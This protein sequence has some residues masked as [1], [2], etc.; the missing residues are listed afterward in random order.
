[1]E[2]EL[3]DGTVLEF[4]DGTDPAVIQATVKKMIAGNAPAAPAPQPAQPSQQTLPESGASK[5][6]S[7]VVGGPVEA[8][9][10]MATGMGASAVGGLAGLLGGGTTDERTQRIQDVSQ[11]LTYQPRPAVGQGITEGLGSAFEAV[12]KGVGKVG[13][14]VGSLFGKELEGQMLG[15]I[16]LPVA[17]TLAGAPSMLRGGR[18]VSAAMDTA[19][20]ARNVAKNSAAIERIQRSPAQAEAA[21]AAQELGVRVNIGESNPTATNRMLASAAGDQLDTS[22]A[23]ANVGAPERIVKRDLGLPEDARLNLDTLETLRSSLA[24]PIEELKSIGNLPISGQVTSKLQ[25]LKLDEVVSE[26]AKKV[27]NRIDKLITNL[28]EGTNATRLWNIIRVLRSEANKGL[29]STDIKTNNMAAA[30]LKMANTLEGAFDEHLTNI[31]NTELLGKV[32]DAR[33]KLA[34]TYAVERMLDVAKERIDTTKLAGVVK[35]DNALTGDLAKLAD[36]AANYPNAFTAHKPN[37]KTHLVRTGIPGTVGMSLGALAGSPFM[38]AA[39][40][41]GV[42]EI[43]SILL[44]KRLAS[45]ASQAKRAVPPQL[46]SPVNF[47]KPT[48]GTAL[49][50]YTHE[51]MLE[52]SGTGPD[53]TFGKATQYPPNVDVNVPTGQPPQL[54]FTPNAEMNRP[55]AAPNTSARID[56]I[57]KAREAS[58]S[59]APTGRGQLYDLDPVTGR[60]VAADQGIKGST[61]MSVESTGSNL[62]TAVNKISSGQSFRLSAEERLAWAKRKVDLEQAAPELKGLS[63]SA[64]A[65]KMTDRKWVSNRI[66]QLKTEYADWARGAAERFRKQQ[67]G[68]LNRIANE[69]PLLSSSEKAARK[70]ANAESARRLNQVMNQRKQ[71]MQAQVDALESMTDQLATSRP[72]SDGSQGPKTREFQRG[73]LTGATQ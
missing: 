15:E 70:A 69:S 1:M 6:L 52:P 55:R 57:L 21:K 7:N 17:G 20:T 32:R 38:G 30:K 5:F 43:G 36:V 58:A 29:Q 18:A 24:T 26:G 60:L 10:S 19:S 65:Q 68:E 49:T 62:K 39:I 35:S 16:A 11:A 31:G 9:L 40:G 50:P 27:N 51:G 42:G 48:Q 64:I 13:G 4:P 54:G 44:G 67:A 12:N 71:A 28:E 37:L 45:Q 56:E 23:K 47:P 66:D 33:A 53:W 34:K 3:A 14:I 2:A 8:G 61:P 72:T 41:A 59:R 73:M 25:G 46:M 63:D 22:I